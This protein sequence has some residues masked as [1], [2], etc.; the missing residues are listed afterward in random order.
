MKTNA[1]QKWLLTIN[2]VLLFTAI[3]LLVATSD[4]GTSAEKEISAI[5]IACIALFILLLSAA[6]IKIRNYTKSIRQIVLGIKTNL[7]KSTDY[8]SKTEYRTRNLG[9]FFQKIENNS[10][11]LEKIN[12]GL[13]RENNSSKDLETPAPNTDQHLEEKFKSRYF[14]PNRINALKIKQDS[15]STI[16]GRIAADVIGNENSRAIRES[17]INTKVDLGEDLFVKIIAGSKHA[18]SIKKIAKVEKIFPHSYLAFEGERFIILDFSSLQEGAWSTSLTSVSGR[19]YI[20]FFNYLIFCKKNGSIVISIKNSSRLE[21]FGDELL[22]IS[23]IVIEENSITT[24][25]EYWGDGISLPII[26]IIRSSEGK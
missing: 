18:D 5:L 25:F 11:L 12:H 20:D 14:S 10:A 7:D 16:S 19:L 21:N 3:I 8:S 9:K 17:L 2:A 4:S 15:S 26:D 1:L 24:D 22:S 13:T 6:F 23:N